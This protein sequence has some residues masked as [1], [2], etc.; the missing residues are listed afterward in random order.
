MTDNPKP[1]PPPSSSPAADEPAPPKVKLRPHWIDRTAEFAGKM[2]AII[3]APP[4]KPVRE[5]QAR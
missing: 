1:A 2:I 5:E 4:P 3:G